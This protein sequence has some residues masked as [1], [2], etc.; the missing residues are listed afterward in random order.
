MSPGQDET[1]VCGYIYIY[2]YLKTAVWLHHGQLWTIN[3]GAVSLAQCGNHLM[4]FEPSDSDY[5]T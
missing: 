3:E 5:N 2:I 4:G 1:R